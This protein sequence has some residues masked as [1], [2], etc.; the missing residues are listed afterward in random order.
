[1]EE[2]LHA[3]K[4]FQLGCILQLLSCKFNHRQRVIFQ[5]HLSA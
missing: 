5:K 4:S 1:M 3:G 2:E